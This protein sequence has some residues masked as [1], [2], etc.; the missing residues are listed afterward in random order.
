MKRELKRTRP[1]ARIIMGMGWML[2]V[3]LAV[4]PATAANWT[5]GG[6]EDRD[7]SNADN[8]D[9]GVPTASVLANIGT[10][11]KQLGQAVLTQPGA[12][13][14][15]LHLA[16][17]ANTTG[18]LEILSGD[19]TA[20]SSQS[21]WGHSGGKAIVTIRGGSLTVGNLYGNDCTVTQEAGVV[22][23]SG[24]LGNASGSHSRYVL[25]DGEL[26]S[27]ATIANGGAATILQSGG[28]NTLRATT[29]FAKGVGGAT[30]S[31][32][33]CR[34]AL[35]GGVLN[36]AGDAAILGGGGTGQ[37]GAGM[38]HLGGGS[39]V[40]T[41]GSSLT[42]R[43]QAGAY[44]RIRGWGAVNGIGMFTMNGQTIA[45]GGGTNRTLAIAFNTLAN[46]IA[47]TA[48]G[49]NGW[50]AVNG[51]RLELPPL[52]VTGN[53][54]TIWGETG[55]AVAAAFDL[56]NA[57]AF[58]FSGVAGNG[59]LAGALC[60]SERADVPKQIRASRVI[61]MWNF[62]AEGF[63]ST[64]VELTVRYDHTAAAALGLTE[65]DLQLFTH[66]GQPGG[67]WVPVETVV[68]TNLR[69]LTVTDLAYTPAY[70]A[71][72]VDIQSTPQSTIMLVR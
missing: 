60:A 51:G 68:D 57:V 42:I 11:S 23:L 66:N 6:G 12:V 5:G 40:S 67:K 8:W 21:D 56:V 47:N 63:S 34:Y 58:A 22:T 4:G 37:F 62:V 29:Y 35:S 16:R 10:T 19:L 33:S 45:D 41:N 9:T 18:E 48:A 24:L 43:N 72:G 71:A 28:T 38:L 13:C 64:H 65:E 25:L 39:V 53:G 44:G 2:L 26:Y 46:G 52:D 30:P 20:G 14:V 36:L 54:T 31:Y 7:W 70:L 27:P 3:G 32:S 69:T 59:T 61:G 55:T 15:R 50:F 17:V 49:T 1:G